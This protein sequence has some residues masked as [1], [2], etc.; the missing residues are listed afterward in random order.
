MAEENESTKDFMNR[1]GA[2]L[3]VKRM[4]TK[5][6]HTFKK[7]ANEEFAGDYGM[8]I[9]FLQD[10]YLGVIAKGNEHLE[11][12]L[13]NLNKRMTALEREPKEDNKTEEI[14]M[15]D[16]STKTLLKRS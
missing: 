4:P 8:Y 5:A 16:G 10:L 15:G 2:A 12:A 7:K 14:K 13:N 1:I 11:V 6:L 9:K 3:L